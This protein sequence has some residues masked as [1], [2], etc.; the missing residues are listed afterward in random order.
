MNRAGHLIPLSLLSTGESAHIHTVAGHP[1]QT[2]RLRELGFQEGA[3]VQMIQ[4]GVPCIIRL[5]NSKLCFR[6]GE[7]SRI[8]VRPRSSA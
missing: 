1:E 4:S 5:E 7:M 6:D 8:M 3:H 2:R